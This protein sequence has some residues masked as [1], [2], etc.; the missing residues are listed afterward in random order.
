M[1]LF[2]MASEAGSITPLSSLSYEYTT[3]VEYDSTYSRSAWRST[4]SNS[5]SRTYT[6]TGQSTGYIHFRLVATTTVLVAYP[7]QLCD[8]SGKAWVRL[9]VNASN[10]AVYLQY[11]VGTTWTSVGPYTVDTSSA[12]TY[13]IFWNANASGKVQLF[14]NSTLALDSGTVDLSGMS[15]ITNIWFAGGAASGS[16]PSYVSEIIG[17]TEATIGWRL[18]TLVPTGNGNY[19]TWTNDYT[20]VD[21]VTY[22]DADFIY[23]GTNTDKET[24]TFSDPTLGSFLVKGVGVA[25]RAKCDSTGPQ[26]LQHLVRISAVDYNGS[27]HALNVGY[28]SY[29]TIW[30]TS[31]A[32]STTWTSAEV[33]ALEAGVEA[34]T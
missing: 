32:T 31:P 18:A 17:S 26:N 22:S 33:N 2:L 27:S 9:E 14:V 5:L 28:D 30:A 21:E 34:I 8:S 24:Y 29:V 11:L 10:T 20:A 4:N 15:N 1:T 6:F 23:D 13:D 16:T 3:V 19:T 7:V 25:T 12:Q